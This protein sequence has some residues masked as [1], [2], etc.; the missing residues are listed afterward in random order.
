MRKIALLIITL[1]TLLACSDK[2]IP[3]V[4]RIS[5]FAVHINSIA[6]QENISFTEAA[7]LVRQTT[8]EPSPNMWTA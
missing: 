2:K 3:A 5:V 4:D 8:T 6:Q 1:L 7:T